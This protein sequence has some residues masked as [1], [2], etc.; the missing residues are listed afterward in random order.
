[1]PEN[2]CAVILAG[3]EG[4]RMKSERPKV[5]FE[6]LLKPMLEWVLDATAA[7]GISDRCV[8]TGYL[9]EQVEGYLEGSAHSGVARVW[10]SE[11]RGTGHAVMTAEGFLESH[12]GGDVLILNGDSP[13]LSATLIAGAYQEH[14]AG[15]NSVTVI[16][17]KVGNPT[18]Y[19]RIVRD[20]QTQALRAI[21]EQK[22][23]DEETLRIQEVN[24]GAFWFRVDDLLAV[25]GKIQNHNAQG[26]YYLP[27]A[28]KLLLEEGKKAGAYASDDASA[29][30]GANDCSQ[31]QDLNGIAREKVFRK[32]LAQGVVI[33][34]KD[35]V[36]I[37]PD[38]VIGAGS[39]I[40]PGTLVYGKTV[41]GK[42]CTIGPNTVLDSCMVGDGSIL[43]QIN[44]RESEFA[45]GS[46][47]APFQVV[48]HAGR[49]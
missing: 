17:A 26:E 1:M 10:Q 18:G 36:L 47:P 43:S 45:P 41:I 33:P 46:A 15:K 27:D 24:S 16:S 9:R 42:G 14:H 37:G 39:R 3:G 28:V 8:V 29:V 31:L 12:R 32:L 4:K 6:V 22:D 21:I 7:A 30:L 23:A 40:Y 38:A 25:L 11:R 2:Q 34:C 44:A 13:F 48:N 20:P 19:G 5:L 49:L 35:G